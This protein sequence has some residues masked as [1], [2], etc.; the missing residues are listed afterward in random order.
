MAKDYN[1]PSVN[2]YS[3]GKEI[4]ETGRGSVVGRELAE[5]AA[6]GQHV[7]ERRDEGR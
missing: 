1:H 3:I 6:G 7:G 5:K 4:P 2:F